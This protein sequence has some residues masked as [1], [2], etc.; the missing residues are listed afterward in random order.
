MKN[1]NISFWIGFALFHHSLFIL[2]GFLSW[3]LLLAILILSRWDYF[4]ICVSSCHRSLYCVVCTIRIC[5][6][7]DSNR[8]TLEM[9]N[10][11]LLLIIFFWQWML[12]SKYSENSSGPSLFFAGERMFQRKRAHLKFVLRISFL[13][14]FFSILAWNVTKRL[15]LKTRKIYAFLSFSFN[16]FI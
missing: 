8:L 2:L 12:S 1:I 15:F 10:A 7:R 5:H 11:I 14:W 6:L 13:K 4:T 16:Y 9:G 3:T